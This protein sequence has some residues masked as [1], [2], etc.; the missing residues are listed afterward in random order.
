[1]S[2]VNLATPAPEVRTY[3]FLCDLQPFLDVRLVSAL[4]TYTEELLTS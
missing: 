3:T 4:R 1:M 2:A